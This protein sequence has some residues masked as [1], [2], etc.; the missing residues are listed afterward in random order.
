MKSFK[1]PPKK[2]RVSRLSRHLYDIARIYQSE[3]QQKAYDIKLI[4]SIIKHRERFN[5][6]RGV[7]YNSLYPPNLNPIPPEEFL[8]DWEADYKSMQTNM[9]PEES[10]NFAEILQIVKQATKEYNKLKIDK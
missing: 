8:K 4:K 3:H 9:I 5:G 7:D 6:M 1:K 10:P 2:I